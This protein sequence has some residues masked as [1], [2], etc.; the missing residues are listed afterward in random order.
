MTI[1][2]RTYDFKDGDKG[3]IICELTAKIGRKTKIKFIGVGHTFGDASKHADQA[4]HDWLAS[5]R[6]SSTYRKRTA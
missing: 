4:F 6:V 3:R 2:K 5:A 1:T